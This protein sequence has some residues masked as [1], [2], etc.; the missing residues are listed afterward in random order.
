MLGKHVTVSALAGICL[1]T[2]GEQNPLAWPGKDSL[3]PVKQGKS[4]IKLAENPNT[5]LVLTH[6]LAR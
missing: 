4:Q 5:L 1:A 2:A 3:S 6:S